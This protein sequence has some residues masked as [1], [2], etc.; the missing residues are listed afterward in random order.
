MRRGRAP[1]ILHAIAHHH[2]MP[3]EFD[4]IARY[5]SPPTAHTLLAGGDDAALIVPG[6]G[7]ELAVST[8]MLVAG[9]HFFADADPRAIGH[10]ALAVNLSDMAAMGAAPRWATLSLALAEADERWLAEFAAGFLDLAREHG[11]DLIGGDTTSGPLNICVQIMGEVPA[12]RAL[13]RSGARAGDSI[14]V[15]GSVGDAALGLAHLHGEIELS[16]EE[17][18]HCVARLERP[19]PRVAL[20]SALLGTASSAI[21]VSDG[22]VADLGHIAARSNSLAVL[23]WEQVPLGPAARGRRSHPL[24]RQCALGGG[25]DY[26]LCFTAPANRRGEVLAIGQRLGL[27]VTEIG[28]IEPGAG[29]EV[30]DSEGRAMPLARRGFDHFG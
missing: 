17:A 8:D 4:L 14:W 29:V 16:A 10:K 24:V 30:R 20:G 22:L 26:E 28:R 7:M 11:V 15:S 21:D 25:D 23:D 13:R 2:P 3:S 1:F 12:G 19:A 5:F 18:A 6:A 9:R 27:P